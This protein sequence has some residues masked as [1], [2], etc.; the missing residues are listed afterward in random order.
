MGEPTSASHITG[1]KLDKNNY[2]AWKFRIKNFLMGKEL[3]ELCEGTDAKP[4]GEATDAAVRAWTKKARQAI[5]YISITVSD[6]MIGHIQDANSPKE[7]WD[8]LADLFETSTK[9][10]KLQL[11]Q[12]LNEVKKGSLSINDYVLKI[13]GLTDQLGSIGVV[14]DDDDLLLVTLQGLGK[15]YKPFETSIAVRDTF[16]TFNELIPLL[17]SEE[18]RLGHG[19]STGGNQEH[20]LIAGRG[21]GRGRGFQRGRGRGRFGGQGRGYGGEGQQGQQDQQYGQQYGQQNARGRGSNR[22]RG[23]YQNQEQRPG[24]CNYCGYRGHWA[25]ECRRKQNDIR[26][27]KLPQSNYASTEYEGSSRSDQLLAMTHV[28]S[29]N[30]QESADDWY[31]DSGASNHMTAHAEWFTTLEPVKALS[32]VFT[33]DDSQHEITHMGNVPVQLSAG[34]IKALGEVLHVPS[35]TKNLIS[36]GQMVERNFQVRFNQQG[37]FI[38][39]MGN[40]M[41]LIARGKKHGR[42]FKLD[43]IMPEVEAAMYAHTDGQVSDIEMW[44][45]RIGHMNY[46]RL[47]TLPTSGIVKGVPKFRVTGPATVCSACQ[48]GKQA[49]LPFPKQARRAHRI[50]ELIHSDVWMPSQP[51]LSGYEYYVSFIDDYSR[52]TWVYF[53]KRKNEVLEKF[54][55]FKA[56]VEK[57]TGQHI[58]M[59]RSDNGGEYVSNEFNAYLREHGIKREKSCGYSPQQNGVAERKNRHIAEVARAMMDEKHMPRPYWAEAVSC[60]VY[61]MNRT[62]TSAVHDITPEEAFTNVKPDMSHMKVFGCVCYVHIPDEKRRKLDPKAEKCVF[63]GYASESKGYRCYNPSTKKFQ[64]SRDVVFDELNSWFKPPHAIGQDASVL[65]ETENNAVHRLA[66]DSP[67]KSASLGPGEVENSPKP[68]TPWTGRLRSN[69]GG[70]GQQNSAHNSPENSASNAQ[71]SRTVRSTMPVQNSPRNVGATVTSGQ[72]SNMA[73]ISPNFSSGTHGFSRDMGFDDGFENPEVQSSGNVSFAPRTAMDGGPRRSERVKYPVQRLTYDGLMAVHHAYM[74][75][76]LQEKEPES[77]EEAFED[78]KWV[79]AMD[80]EIHAL[81]KQGT[82]TLADLPEGKKA[83]GCKWVYKVKHNSDGSVGRYKARLVAKGYAQE[84]GIDFEETFSPVAKMATVR[85]VIALATHSK[86]AMH[87]MDV[88]NAFLNGDLI[89]EVYMVQPPGYE[90]PNQPMKVCKLQ[91]ALYGLKQAPRAWYGRINA[92]LQNIGFKTCQADSSL[93]AYVQGEYIVLLIIYVDDLIL[94]GSSDM[95]IQDIKSKLKGEFDMKD[96]GELKYFLGIEIIRDAYDTWMVQRQ[97]ALDMLSRYGMTACKPIS[98]P[99]EQNVK[100]RADTGDLLEDPAMYRQ[101][102]GSLIYMT[103]TRPDLSYAVGLVSQFMQSPRKPHL[104]AV[105]RILRYVK[106]TVQYG[107][108]FRSFGDLTLF[109]YTDADWAGSAQDRRSTSGYVFSLGSAA[110]TWSSKKQPTVA[111][112]STE[113]EYRGAALAACESVWLCS[114]LADLGQHV[115]GPISLYCDNMSSIQLASNPVFHARTKHIEVHYHFIREKVLAGQIDMSYVQ[116]GE[117]VADIFTKA[118]P[119]DKFENF[120]FF[121]G[122]RKLSLSLRGSVA[123]IASSSHHPA[124]G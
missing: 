12:Q 13:R 120:R 84:Y 56:L 17:V 3:W 45:K 68:I 65:A 49:R 105:R 121:M 1:E 67:L 20:A 24:S 81:H 79:D 89:E 64:I 7:V 77:I 30:M 93:Y 27:G 98:V 78:P 5:H 19:T 107:L 73:H 96:L 85:T 110:V 42:M 14:V 57:Q 36:V 23:N 108:H 46:N 22:G 87:Q 113:A 62:P 92:F 52:K 40:H 21:R 55:E 35:I 104:D 72:P 8:A 38:E 75:K 117:Q 69:M 114:L 59:L 60:A 106:S 53:L 95:L 54:K 32:Y 100:L 99:L 51:S 43:A 15:E 70:L 9:A 33:G 25:K 90:D 2:P 61:I 50:L 82:W 101:M 10:R 37:C 119:R 97:Y 123:D 71:Q 11:K 94:T 112:S 74:V 111:L 44:H 88:K 28:M 39:D 31:I 18:M 41:Q 66:V 109:G 58:L 103:I 83:I 4:A 115:S 16:P 76:V 118:L 34:D 6:S 91:K 124:I 47:K 116:T 29:T 80:D 26:S 102:V 63:L 86:W 122:V 48:T